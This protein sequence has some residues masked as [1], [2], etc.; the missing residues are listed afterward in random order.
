M[1]TH[2]IQWIY[3]N[4][5]CFS[6]AVDFLHPKWWAPVYTKSAAMC[7]GWLFQ[8]LVVQQAPT[9]AKIKHFHYTNNERSFT[10]WIYNHCLTLHRS[11]KF[12][13]YEKWGIFRNDVTQQ[14]RRRRWHHFWMAPAWDK[15]VQKTALENFYLQYLVE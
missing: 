15:G 13:S 12:L 4:E 14:R 7:I 1:Q 3:L 11:L 2:L 9:L 8:K 6:F 10:L 5:S